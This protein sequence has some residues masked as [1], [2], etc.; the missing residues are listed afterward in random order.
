LTDP[1][2]VTARSELGLD[3]V[4]AFPQPLTDEVVHAADVVVTMGC[5]DA[6][7]LLPG[8]QYLDWSVADRPDNRFIGSARSETRSSVAW[9]IS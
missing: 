6:W 9:W 7:L 2:V 4:E 1:A 8:K 5:G 3:L